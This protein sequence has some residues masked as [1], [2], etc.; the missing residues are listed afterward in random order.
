[1]ERR[2]IHAIKPL[3][4]AEM[5]DNNISFLTLFSNLEILEIHG[6]ER[7]HCSRDAG[8]KLFRVPALSPSQYTHP[9]NSWGTLRSQLGLGLHYKLSLVAT[10]APAKSFMERTIEN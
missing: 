10:T 6:T 2:Q 9:T 5:A 3:G 1:M 4:G 7:G 8:W